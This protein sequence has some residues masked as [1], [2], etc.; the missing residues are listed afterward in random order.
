MYFW[1]GNLG[2]RDDLEDLGD[3]KM[4]FKEMLM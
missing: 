3:I 4:D 1:W 2:E